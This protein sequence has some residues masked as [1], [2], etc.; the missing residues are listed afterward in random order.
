MSL[1]IGYLEYGLNILIEKMLN[2]EENNAEL[3][4]MMT[5][6]PMSAAQHAAITRKKIEQ[7]RLAEDTRDA[8]RYLRDD[9]KYL[10]WA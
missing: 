6:P 8:D 4:D 2:I 1:R 7:R 3:K 9:F 5:V 10:K